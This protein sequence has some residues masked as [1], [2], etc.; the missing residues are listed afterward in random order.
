L[1]TNYFYYTKKWL[2]NF[3]AQD[4]DR[5]IRDYC[6]LRSAKAR[7]NALYLLNQLEINIR[8][9]GVTKSPEKDAASSPIHT[10]PDG[11]L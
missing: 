4:T 3:N 6:P 8:V 5:T 10:N 1:Q 7:E 2:L 11:T 9:F